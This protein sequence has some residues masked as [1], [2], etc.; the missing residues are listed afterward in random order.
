MK[1]G[2]TK[3]GCRRILL[4][5][6]PETP[7]SGTPEPTEPTAYK[8]FEAKWLTENPDKATKRQELR[9]GLRELN[10]E[11]LAAWKEQ[12]SGTP[13]R[14]ARNSVDEQSG[15]EG[16]NGGRNISERTS[17]PLNKERTTAAAVAP[18]PCVQESEPPPPDSVECIL[19]NPWRPVRQYVRQHLNKTIP[20]HQIRAFIEQCKAARPGLTPEVLLRLLVHF[21]EREIGS[22][23]HSP[24]DSYPA[25]FRSSS[26]AT[27][28]FSSGSKTPTLHRA[29]GRNHATRLSARNSTDSFGRRSMAPD[30]EKFTKEEA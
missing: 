7:K 5:G 9:K 30:D 16:T 1:M 4:R 15:T 11:I 25:K 19:P 28:A 14:T 3:T 13:R 8:T 10:A 23:I 29:Q 24:W 6:A 27:R 18:L 2:P 22:H 21:R 12:E 20:D 26:P 17:E